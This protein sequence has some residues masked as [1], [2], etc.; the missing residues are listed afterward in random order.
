[1]L[2]EKKRKNERKKK[3]KNKDKKARVA[4]TFMPRPKRVASQIRRVLGW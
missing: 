2:G 4:H 1:M 3:K